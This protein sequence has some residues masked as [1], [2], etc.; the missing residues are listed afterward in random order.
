MSKTKLVAFDL[1]RWQKGDFKR[2]VDILGTEIT[3]LTYFKDVNDKR[4]LRGVRLSAIESWRSNGSWFD[5]PNPL[6][7]FLEVEDKTL[8]GWV[9]VYSNNIGHTVYADKDTAIRHKFYDNYITTIKITYP[10][11]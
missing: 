1:E 3:Q 5:E 8:E 10:N 7:L 9:N 11:E 4:K 6:D 2:V